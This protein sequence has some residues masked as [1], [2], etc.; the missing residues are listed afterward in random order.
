MLA[1]PGVRIVETTTGGWAISKSRD[2]GRL[3]IAIKSLLNLLLKGTCLDQIR[4]ILFGSILMTLKKCEGLHPIAIGYFWHQLASKCAS[5]FTL[6]VMSKHL[7]P[8]QVG[9]GCP[10]GCETAVDLARRFILNMTEDHALKKL[11]FINAFNS[12]FRDSRLA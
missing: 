2:W 3:V 9:M 7:A 1:P 5:N 11:D 6:P 8:P 12:K 10:G 4:P